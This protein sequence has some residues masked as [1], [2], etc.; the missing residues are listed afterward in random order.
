MVPALKKNMLYSLQKISCEL[1]TQMKAVAEYNPLDLF[2]I[3][4]QKLSSFLETFFNFAPTQVDFFEY[5]EQ[6]TFLRC[7]SGVQSVFKHLALVKNLMYTVKLAINRWWVIFYG[8]FMAEK[9]PG[10]HRDSNP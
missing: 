8:D 5:R 9:T 2:S 7:K 1:Q 6:I 4:L 10:H 3:E